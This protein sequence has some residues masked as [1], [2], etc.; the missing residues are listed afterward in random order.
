MPGYEAP[1]YISWTHVNRSDLI[2]VPAYNP[3]YESSVRIEYRAPDPAN[4]SYSAIS[5]MLAARQP[6]EVGAGDDSQGRCPPGLILFS[7]PKSPQRVI[8]EPG[9]LAI[10][11]LYRC[12]GLG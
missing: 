9:R 7:P 10:L 8:L 5:V 3:G 12:I 1:G 2:R 11:G 4:N 6:T